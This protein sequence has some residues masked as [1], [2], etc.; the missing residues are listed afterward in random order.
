MSALLESYLTTPVQTQVLIIEREDNRRVIE[1][2]T[3][4][5]FKSAY[6]ADVKDLLPCSLALIDQNSRIKAA[7]GYQPANHHRLYLEQYLPSSIEQCI[8]QQLNIK[9]PR[10]EDIVEVGNL[11]SLTSGGTLRLIINLAHYF[12]NIGFKWM[13]MT[14]IPQVITIFEKLGV[15]INLAPLIEAKKEALEGSKSQW[16]NYYAKQP[17]V[18][19]ANIH[20][21]IQSIESNQ[22][23][24]KIINRVQPPITDV[25]Y[26]L[27]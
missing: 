6:D 21:S 4:D 9:Q 7:M 12:K 26:Q 10:R 15:D 20:E 1:N 11:A 13:V 19:C 18:V 16:G 25:N 2:F 17:V 27:V 23:M 8:A 5:R 22:L 3:I 24:A 14:A